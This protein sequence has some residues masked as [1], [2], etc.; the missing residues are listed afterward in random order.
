MFH[1]I[2]FI[3]KLVV[4]GLARAFLLA[5]TRSVVGSAWDVEDRAAGRFMTLFYQG[6]AMGK[7]RDVALSA[8]RRKMAD[9]GPHLQALIR[10]GHPAAVRHGLEKL[11]QQDVMREQLIATLRAVRS[12]ILYRPTNGINAAQ[13]PA[14][15]VLQ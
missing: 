13:P 2:I 14:L 8:T 12:S 1:V 7:P 6:L 15:Q 10:A 3:I 4:F 5:G 9:E 11:R